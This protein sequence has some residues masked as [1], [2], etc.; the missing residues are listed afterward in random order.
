MAKNFGGVS[1]D[2]VTGGVGDLK[3]KLD[4]W[5]VPGHDNI[6][7]QSL[8]SSD[9]AFRFRLVQYDTK[10]NI[11]TWIGNIE[12]L[13]GTIVSAEDDL[14]ITYT[15]NLAVQRVSVADRKAVIYQGAN[16]VRGELSVQG[17]VV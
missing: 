1:C 5:D 11:E 15:S 9:S 2:L 14:E 8:G 7:L 17:V 13:Q 4:T 12:A 6:G 10:A 16:R 3:T